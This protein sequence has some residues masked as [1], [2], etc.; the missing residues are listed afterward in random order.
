MAKSLII[1][2]S[3]SKAKTINKYLGKDYIVE[4]T[5]GHIKNLP[6]KDL[7]VDVENGFEPRYV[8]IR[9]KS[10]II[11]TLQ[12]KAEKA[13][14]IYIATDPDREGEAIAAHIADEL[15]KAAKG[16]EVYRVLFN[17][18]TKSGI[19]EAMANPRRI[20]SNMVKA[21][22][23]RRVMDRIVGYKVSPFLWKTIYS[24]LSAGRVQSVALRFICEREQEIAA[25]QIT[26]YWSVTGEF[27]KPGDGTVH[28]KLVKIDGKD[29][30]IA[31]ETDALSLIEKL[32]RENYA[33]SDIQM[34]DVNR[35]PS[36]P[37]ITSSLQ[38]E[39]SNRLRFSA[40]RTMIIAQQLYEGVELGSEGAVG[41]ITYMRTDST[42]LS[43]EAINAV[44]EFIGKTYGSEY[45]P[46]SPR[47]FKV[48]G[49]AQDA[50]EAIRP[51][52]LEHT[53]QSVKKFLT[54]EQY[55]L[56]ELIWKRFVA[57][58]MAPALIKQT[59]VMIAGGPYLFRGVGSVYKFRG[60]LQV[61]DDFQPETQEDENEEEA[62]IPENLAVKDAMNPVSLDPHQHF[63]KPPPRYT[64]SSLVRELEAKGIG[65][66]S[67]YA[68]IVSTIQDRGYVEQKERRLFA[69]T[70]GMD[71]NKML[72]NYFEKLFNVD[73]TAQMEEELDTIASGERSY[74][75]VM[76]DFYNPFMSLLNGV[77]VDQAR[78]T[79]E[80][81]EVCDK[82]GKPMIIRWGRNGKFLACSGYP[83]CK[84]AKPLPGDSERMKL[85]E[86]CPECGND[87]IIKQSR[88]GKFIGCT[89]YPTCKYIRPI[90]LGVK[91]PKCK[92]GEIVERQSKSRRLFYG[93]TRYP[94]C[95]FVSWDKP[96][97]KTCPQCE[98]PYLLH[99]YTQKKGEFLKCPQCKN[100][101]TQ[102]LDPFDP[103]YAAA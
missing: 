79:E 38:Q 90:T 102:E 28:T 52:S 36:P 45:V 40:K 85:D 103:L 19:R 35:S 8:T 82:C 80:T 13:E 23:A 73:F 97:A 3:P 63:T 50:H 94:E 46:D 71:V 43:N 78:L 89:N 12:S 92:E 69:T 24:G 81:S 75:V 5:I 6:S 62:I 95:D 49:K 67:T 41:L 66:P 101:F 98:N 32:R 30:E 84:N 70:L 7:G 39:A 99:K 29:P 18:I 33:I 21:Q 53:P 72:M 1:V 96:V 56:Y 16:K 9:G 83:E 17:E 42:R 57:C 26:E 14:S 77:S 11:K 47:V 2:E 10:Q 100:E 76:N 87:L 54:P 68:L 64:E 34:K 91:C 31:N 37:F 25:F 51:T 4:A 88:Y 59:T 15:D 22:Q 20:D 27:E 55:A 60:F 44:R 65:R 86:K 61:Y 58:Q 48:K 93:C 74:G